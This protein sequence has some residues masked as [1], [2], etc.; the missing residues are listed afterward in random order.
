MSSTVHIEKSYHSELR[1]FIVADGCNFVP[2][3]QNEKQ[4]SNMVSLTETESEPTGTLH[5][6]GYI[7]GGG[8]FSANRLV[9]IAGCGDYQVE[10]IM[11]A[12]VQSERR[13]K[14]DDVEMGGVLDLADEPLAQKPHLSGPQ[15]SIEPRADNSDD[16]GVLLLQAS[17][18]R[19]DP[20]A[21]FVCGAFDL[22]AGLGRDIRPRRKR[23]RH[24]RA[25]HA[26]QFGHVK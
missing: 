23:P 9:H 25:R 13:R 16:A 12:T 26:G 17:G 4:G 6:T 11:D 19:I 7:R 20:V 24:R 18:Q 15:R 3:N 22:L 8:L 14:N 10:R 2:N 1:S 21:Q 5:V